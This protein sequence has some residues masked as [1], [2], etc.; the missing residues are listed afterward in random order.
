MLKRIIKKATRR[1]GAATT[2][3]NTF[4]AAAPRPQNALDIFKGEW[5]VAMPKNSGLQAGNFPGDFFH[6]RRVLSAERAFNGFHGK[7]IL[8]LGPCEGH[9]TVMIAQR[10][11]ELVT[12]I[13]ANTR[14]YLKCLI[15]K[16]V[17][18]LTNAHFLLGNAVEFMKQTPE[19]FDI[20]FASGFLYHQAEPDKALAAMSR[21]SDQIFVQT[22]YFD[23]AAIATSYLSGHFDPGRQVNGLTYYPMRYRNRF[24]PDYLGG[25][26]EATNWI[27]K[28]DLLRTIRN[29]GFKVEIVNDEITPNGPSLWFVAT[30]EKELREVSGQ[31]P[32]NVTLVEILN[33]DIEPESGRCWC[34]SIPRLAPGDSI[35]DGHRSELALFEDGKLMGPAHTPHDDIR[36]HGGG[37]FSHWEDTLFFSTSDNS[38]PRSSGRKYRVAG[39]GRGKQPIAAAPS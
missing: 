29:L 27:G 12:A 39:P 17:F 35:E 7:T 2:I 15:M 31:K 10:G 26:A 28:D 23:A 32:T 30:R 1:D 34:A 8:E 20:L 13:E 14:A 11:A 25:V 24:A 33:A 18:N 37:L 22:H 38:D 16:E 21:V 19:Q 4:V 6:D 36:Q 3:H 5:T 9:H